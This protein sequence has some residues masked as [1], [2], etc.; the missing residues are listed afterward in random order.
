MTHDTQEQSPDEAAGPAAAPA[1][2]DTNNGD[3]VFAQAT[4]ERIRKL[5][6]EVGAVLITV[7]V[8]GVILPGPIGMPLLLAGGLALMPSWFGKAEQWVG[9]KFPRVHNEGMK[10]VN[11]FIDDFEKRF[12]DRAPPAADASP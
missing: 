5:P 3:H 12:P 7:G 1:S 9:K 8:V 6:P 11:R 2:A 10:N 4:R